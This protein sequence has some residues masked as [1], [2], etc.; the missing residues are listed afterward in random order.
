MSNVIRF[1][2]VGESTAVRAEK[3]FRALSALNKLFKK[4]V[5]RN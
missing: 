4:R 5:L 1:Y 3:N 2:N